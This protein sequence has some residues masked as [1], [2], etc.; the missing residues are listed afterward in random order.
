MIKNRIVVGAIGALF[1][2]ATA[3]TVQ[4]QSVQAQSVEAQTR[5]PRRFTTVS[6]CTSAQLAAGCLIILGSGTP[7]PEPTRAGAAYAVAFG[8][9]TFLFDAGAGVMRRTAAAGLPIDGFTAAFLTHLHS[10]HTLGLADVMLTS[11]VMGRRGPFPLTGPTGTQTLVNHL[12]AAYADDINVR[13]NG[14]ERGQAAGPGVVVHEVTGGVVYDSAGVRITA[15]P[16]PHGEWKTAFAYVITLPTRTIVLSGDAAPGP[17]L[18]RAAAG[19][20]ILVH[21][22]YPSVRLKPEDRP[23]GE[24]WPDYMRTV[25][26]S[27][28][29]V[30]ALAAQAGVKLLLLSHIVR[31]GG[32][33]EELLAGVRQGGFRGPV[34]IAADLDAY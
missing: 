13:L 27:D 24:A 22:T 7:V 30:G 2:V 21:E 19:A 18:V 4:A 1:A 5:A 14:G 16:V 12:M 10:D 34:R 17:A 6:P 31:M 20:D 3:Q 15:V 33:D 8:D 9:R 32:T 29:E 11:W 25:H 28:V 26:T 23:G